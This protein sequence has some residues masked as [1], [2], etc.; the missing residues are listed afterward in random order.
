MAVL[1]TCVEDPALTLFKF[2]LV[3]KEP[4]PGNCTMQ[5]VHNMVHIIRLGTQSCLSPKVIF[6]CHMKL[7]TFK[8]CSTVK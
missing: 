2:I 4:L 6:T 5:I 7:A 1:P 3:S 8:K